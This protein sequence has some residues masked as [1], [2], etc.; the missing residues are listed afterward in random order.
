VY[1]FSCVWNWYICTRY[2]GVG[3]PPD[4]SLHIVYVCCWQLSRRAA[5][6]ARNLHPAQEKSDL[7]ALFHTSNMLCNIIALRFTDYKR[8]TQTASLQRE[9]VSLIWL[10]GHRQAGHKKKVISL[11]CCVSD[12]SIFRSAHAFIL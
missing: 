12:A 9:F 1:T 3:K 11:S 5:V 6:E 4:L 2:L 8:Q 7:S 10:L